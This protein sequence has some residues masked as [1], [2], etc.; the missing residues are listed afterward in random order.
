MFDALHIPF[1]AS[2]IGIV[3]LIWLYTR[4]SG[5]KTIVWTDSFQTFCLLAALGLI[6][7][8]VSEQMNLG[9]GGMVPV[10][11]SE[12]DAGAWLSLP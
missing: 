9:V 10:P 3:I 6:L 12:P 5:I 4:K 7:F 2:V 11:A 1:T 8:Q